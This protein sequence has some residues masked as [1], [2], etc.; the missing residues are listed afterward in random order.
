MTAGMA[1]TSAVDCG[2]VALDLRLEA[3]S[4]ARGAQLAVVADE[5][6][7]GP[8]RCGCRS[9]SARQADRCDPRGVV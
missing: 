1:A 5:D 7:H 3:A 8:G 9:A 6:H 4:A 2:A